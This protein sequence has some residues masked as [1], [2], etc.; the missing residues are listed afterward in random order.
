MLGPKGVVHTGV[1]AV[2]ADRAL[3]AA[4]MSALPARVLCTTAE[5]SMTFLGLPPS[6]GSDL[7]AR[8]RVLHVDAETALAEVN[9]RDARDRVGCQKLTCALRKRSICR[10]D[11]NFATS[12]PESEV[13]KGED[14]PTTLPGLAPPRGDTNIGVWRPKTPF[15]PEEIPICTQDANFGTPYLLR[16]ALLKPKT[17][18]EG[19]TFTPRFD[20]L[21]LAQ[22]AEKNAN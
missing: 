17:L 22:H 3:I 12:H 20:P 10:R 18:S 15:A 19:F 14:M 2:L 9:V 7:A 13:E 1:L 21:F 5:L 8:A 11:S 4:V 6:A 16:R